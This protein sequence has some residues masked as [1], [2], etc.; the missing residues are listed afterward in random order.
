M[1]AVLGNVKQLTKEKPMKRFILKVLYPAITL[2]NFAQYHYRVL[3]YVPKGRR[4]MVAVAKRQ[5]GRLLRAGK[6]VHWFAELAPLTPSERSI[7]LLSAL[8]GRNTFELHDG[9]GNWVSLLT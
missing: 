5:L 6:A 1:N 4:G 3:R 7:V 8:Y 9:K 2:I